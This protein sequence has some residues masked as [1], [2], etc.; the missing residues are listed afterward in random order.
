MKIN[1][2]TNDLQSTSMIDLWD[3]YY[4]YL[5][6]QNRHNQYVTDLEI[7]FTTKK[8]PEAGC[9][10][11]AWYGRPTHFDADDGFDCTIVDHMQHH[12]EVCTPTAFELLQTRKKCFILSGSLVPTWHPMHDKIICTSMIFNTLSYYVRPFNPHYFEKDL[13]HE[14]TQNILYINGQNRANRQYLLD[15]ISKTNPDL[16]IRNTWSTIEKCHSSF[17]ESAD[18]TKF[19]KFVNSKY[20]VECADHGYYDNNVAIGFNQKFG[21]IP[22]GFSLIDQY[23]QS[24]CVIFPET[25]WLNNN[26]FLT[27][28]IMKCAIART[29]PWPVAGSRINQLYNELG[30][31]TAWNL[32]PSHLQSW[33]DEENHFGRIQQMMAAISWMQDH[34]QIWTSESAQKIRQHNRCAVF[35]NSFDSKCAIKLHAIL[36]S[37]K[38]KN[39]CPVT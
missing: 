24:E 14:K 28:K 5:Q 9:V 1:I 30:F 13:C 35:S 34:P 36:Q 20:S 15:W 33:D 29:I 22:L 25:T 7:N 37:I 4:S 16:P 2:K 11:I 26:V 8:T 12:L 27:E 39:I 38:D 17:F 18:D 32:L 10:N 23:F 19:R 21:S 3:I 6:F 31:Q